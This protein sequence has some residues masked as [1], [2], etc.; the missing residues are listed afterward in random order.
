[1]GCPL[2]RCKG[3]SSRL[4][5]G[6][7]L[8][9]MRCDGKLGCEWKLRARQ[10][11]LGALALLVQVPYAS[12]RCDRVH[13]AIWHTWYLPRCCGFKFHI[14]HRRQFFAHNSFRCRRLIGNL[15]P[16]HDVAFGALENAALPVQVVCC[17]DRHA[18][19]QR[20]HAV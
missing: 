5:Y 16:T 6:L 20:Q 17:T 12:A 8:R 19:A 11:E 13:V 2:G 15:G 10:T 1:M 7:P 18:D 9:D 14:H 4:F 3:R